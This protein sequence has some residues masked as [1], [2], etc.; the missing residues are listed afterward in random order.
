MVQGFLMNNSNLLQEEKEPDNET[1]SIVTNKRKIERNVNKNPR[2]RNS[3]T[4]IPTL[5]FSTTNIILLGYLLF[6]SPVIFSSLSTY[7]KVP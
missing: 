5:V 6:Y 3:R 7:E 2:R 1:Y 4:I